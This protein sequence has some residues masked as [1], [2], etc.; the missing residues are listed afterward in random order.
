[1]SRILTLFN[2]FGGFELAKEYTKTGFLFRIPFQLAATGLSNKGLEILRLSANL[3]LYRYLRKRYW[4]YIDTIDFSRFEK[5]HTHCNKVW[6]CWFQ[7]MESAPFVVQKCYESM[8]RNLKNKE[9]ILL[10]DDNIKDFVEFPDYIWE[11]YNS[12][13]FTKT[14]FTDLL[15]LE[16]LIKYGG[17]WIDST[18]LMTGDIPQYI[19]NSE[20]FLFQ[21]LKPGLDGE[22]VGISS[23]FISASTNNKLLITVR[24]LMY[25]YWRRNRKLIDYFLIHNFIRMAMEKFPEEEERMV[26]APNSTPHILLLDMFKPFD[27]FKYEAMK[28]MTS[29]HKLAYKRSEED[30]SKKGTY[31]YEIINKNNF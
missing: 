11:R 5:T 16:L 27:S 13:C 12:G 3:K 4:H 15:R 31:F 20:L 6:V 14:H 1:M 26:K 2:K 28:Q 7:G 24:E 21:N 30:M 8:Q 29:I 9:I 18:V 19:S 10:T 23:W 17:Y 22:A 25:E